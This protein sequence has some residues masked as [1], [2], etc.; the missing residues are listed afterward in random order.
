MQSFNFLAKLSIIVRLKYV[1]FLMI[2]YIACYFTYNTRKELIKLAITPQMYSKMTEKASPKSDVKTNVSTAFLT[3]GSICTLGQ[4]IFRIF[5]D[6]GFSREMSYT[7]ASIV[8]V[9]LSSVFTGLGLYQKL[10]KYAVAG[11]LVPIT[12]FSNAVSSC[13]LEAKS[14]GYILGVGTKIFTIAGPVILYGCASSV[15]YGI[16]YYFS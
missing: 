16:I 15:I 10:A 14:E 7:W 12:G 3:G 6:F 2:L 9:V 13:A 11:T 1:Q 8:L 4:I 5:S